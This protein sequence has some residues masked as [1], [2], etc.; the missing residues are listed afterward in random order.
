MTTYAVLKIAN[1]EPVDDSQMKPWIIVSIGILYLSM[2]ILQI[3]GAFY[4]PYS[5][6]NAFL[7]L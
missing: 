7:F 5:P 3:A 2:C 6:G 1:V 4:W